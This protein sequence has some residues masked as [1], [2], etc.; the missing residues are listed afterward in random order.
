MIKIFQST[1]IS[2]IYFSFGSS[3]NSLTNYQIKE[4]CQKKYNKTSCIK[5]LKLKKLNLLEGNRIEIPVI[6]FK[7]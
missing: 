2:I 7:K 3:A 4:I 1:F 6:P 5:N